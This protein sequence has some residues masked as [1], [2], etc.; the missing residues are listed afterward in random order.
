MHIRT[1]YGMYGSI[2]SAWFDSHN[3]I[4]TTSQHHPIYKYTFSFPS[5]CWLDWLLINSY[6]DRLISHHNSVQYI[7]QVQK[8]CHQLN[9]RNLSIDWF[10]NLLPSMKLITITFSLP[11]CDN[12]ICCDCTTVRTIICTTRHSTMWYDSKQNSNA[13]PCHAHTHAGKCGF[14]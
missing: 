6:Y 1:Y 2:S 12:Y 3:W 11:S 7:I 10:I 4:L 13:M 14:E 9:R 8:E 5:L